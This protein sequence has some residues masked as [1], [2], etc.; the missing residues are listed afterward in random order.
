MTNS[1]KEAMNYFSGVTYNK[2][3]KQALKNQGHTTPM[4]ATESTYMKANGIHNP[5]AVCLGASFGQWDGGDGTIPSMRYTGDGGLA[6]SRPSRKS[7]SKSNGNGQT[8][9]II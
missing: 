7:K 4:R 6:M 1:A 5:S 3:K 9:S 8:F 2:K